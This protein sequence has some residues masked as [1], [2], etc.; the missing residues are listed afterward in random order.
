MTRILVVEDDTPLRRSLAIALRANSCTVH[1]V[2]DAAGALR[3]VRSMSYDVVLLDLGLPDLDGI[4]ALPLLRAHHSGPLIVVSARR[5]QSDKVAALDAGADDYLT[6]PFGLPELL[7]RIRA[8]SRRAGAS[9]LL[10]ACGVTLNLAEQTVV[11]PA[12]EAVELTATEWAVLAA[13][14]RARGAVVSADELLSQVWGHDTGQH[15]NY[16]RV[17]I[18]LLRRKLEPDPGHPAVILTR[19]GRGYAL[20]LAP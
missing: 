19:P 1:D 15:G 12:G 14:A 8:Q 6:K 3:A 16:V 5:D 13:L 11:G 9:S 17:Y 10:C 4:A 7:A 20:A 18:N 2:P